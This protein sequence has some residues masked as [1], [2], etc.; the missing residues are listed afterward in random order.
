MDRRQSDYNKATPFPHIVIDNFMR[1]DVV[2]DCLFSIESAASTMPWKQADHSAQIKKR[3]ITD[4]AKMPEE[5]A[6]VVWW[7]NSC[8]MLNFVEQL[9]GIRGLISDANYEGGGIHYSSSGGKLNVHVDFN[10]HPLGLTR[11]INA[12]L[13]LNLDWNKTWNGD[14]ELWKTD[15]SECA[16]T[17]EPTFNK[18]VIF[19]TDDTSYHGWPKVLECP[20][21]RHRISIAMYY[22]TF[23]DEDSRRKINKRTGALFYD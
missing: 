23:E 9:T 4:C 13:F 7:M 12:L 8:T 3:W 5:A 15:R 10:T 19:N 1:E 22:Y 20:D 21:N 18:L 6:K 2:K 16:V 14:L 17:I 11:R